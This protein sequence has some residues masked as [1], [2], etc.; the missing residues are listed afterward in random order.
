MRSSVKVSALET[1]VHELGT[2]IFN[3]GISSVDNDTVSL[4][5]HYSRLC[6]DFKLL[7]LLWT[8]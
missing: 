1:R 7:L 4:S 8:F 6:K 3:H 2:Q 5:H